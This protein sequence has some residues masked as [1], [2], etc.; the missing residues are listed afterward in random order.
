[1]VPLQ[2]F[3]DGM[4]LLTGAVTIIT[5]DGPAG[6]AGFTA[7][8]VCSVTDQPPTLLVCMNRNSYA[9]PFFAGN[10]VLCVNVLSAAQQ[11]L[12]AAFADRALSMPQRFERAYWQRLQ[13]GSPAFEDALVN[14]DGQI[15]A[16][17]EV[18]T[19]SIFYVELRDIRQRNDNAPARGLAYFN[20]HY[21]PL[22]VA[23]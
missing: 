17:H 7:S 11:P 13:T 22:G 3:R 16:T 19:H 21:H 2:Q 23:A 8:A 14:F 6:L 15:V 18:G 20:R 12:S 5:T 4:S 1:M 9:H 10:G